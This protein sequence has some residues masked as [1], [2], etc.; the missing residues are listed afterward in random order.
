MRMFRGILGLAA[1]S[2]GLVAAA[3]Q[4]QGRSGT[5]FIDEYRG[6]LG[7]RYPHPGYRSKGKQAKPRKRSNRRHISRRV[8]RA[9]RRAKAA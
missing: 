5:F 2:L 8:R 4:T 6:I 3:P 7:S 1:A 9:H